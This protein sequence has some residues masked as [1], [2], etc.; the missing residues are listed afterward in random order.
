MKYLYIK[1][2]TF[3]VLVATFWGFGPH[4]SNFL[5]LKGAAFRDFTST[6]CLGLVRIRGRGRF[7]AMVREG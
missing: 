7:T 2:A 1:V 6:I 3:E 4:F 5:A